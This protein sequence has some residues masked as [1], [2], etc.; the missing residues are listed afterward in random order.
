MESTAR[1]RANRTIGKYDVHL[2]DAAALPQ[3]AAGVLAPADDGRLPGL[4]SHT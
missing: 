4:L 1:A 3:I 2:T